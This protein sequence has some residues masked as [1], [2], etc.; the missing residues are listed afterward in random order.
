MGTT[1]VAA[2][3]QGS[4]LIVANVGDSRAYLI[5]KGHVR[6]ISRDHSWVE[7]SMAAGLLTAEQARTHRYRNLVTRALGQ[8]PEVEVDI[9]Q[10]RLKPGDFIVLCSD[11]LTGEVRDADIG[12]AVG[13]YRASEAASEL[14][15]QANRGGG[16]DNISAVVAIVP[17]R[18]AWLSGPLLAAA[19]T[20][21]VLCLA[22]LYLLV[23]SQLGL[24]GLWAKRTVTPES[25]APPAPVMPTA[26]LSPTE[27][28]A[29]SS[30]TGEVTATP[31]AAGS[32][33]SAT[34]PTEG[35]AVALTTAPVT[36]TA[37]QVTATPSTA[38]EPV[39]RL[40][41]GPVVLVPLFWGCHQVEACE[42]VEEAMTGLLTSFGYRVGEL[43]VKQ[44][45][46]AGGLVL[47]LDR[48]IEVNLA[49]APVECLLGT[50][51]GLT[52]HT[53][54]DGQ[55]FSGE[56]ML[57]TRDAQEVSVTVTRSGPGVPCHSELAEGA[58]VV[59]CG[60]PARSAE[61]NRHLRGSFVLLRPETGQPEVWLPQNEY[62]LWLSGTAGALGS[63]GLKLPLAPADGPVKSATDPWLVYAWRSEEAARCQLSL[64][65]VEFEEGTP[66]VFAWDPVQ[67]RFFPVGE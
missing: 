25:V 29:E 43:E 21:A 63:L 10:E 4:Q 30:A 31:V 44:R 7:E 15:A 41:P 8:K 23:S 50:V 52:V 1:L 48:E 39:A 55:F 49:V 60:H 17:G 27:P 45:E 3:I 57:G 9:F 54:K 40:Q 67:A 28:T 42:S 26:A 47:E 65:A 5:R 59:V 66:A 37:V 32:T 58:E 18:P 51:G 64:Q 35:G 14:V 20:G 38:A 13:Q 24:P 12:K 16:R 11:G 2:V 56:L 19:A 61:D 62:R 33:V 53:Q 34:V 22:A 46:F 36:P 6:Q